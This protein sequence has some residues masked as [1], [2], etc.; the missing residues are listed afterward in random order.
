MPVHKISE[1][2]KWGKQGKAYPTKRG[3]EKQAQAAYAN[4]YKE[5]RNAAINVLKKHSR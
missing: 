4:G 1:G 5:K 3:A 2:Y